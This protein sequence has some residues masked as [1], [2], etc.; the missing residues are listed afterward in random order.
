MALAGA[1]AVAG[2][3]GLLWLASLPLPDIPPS[4][5]SSKLLAVDGELIATL[6]GEENRTVVPLAQI[7]PHLSRAVVA[8]E[9]RTFFD[10][11]GFSIRGIVRAARANWQG[12]GIV[13]G[14]STITQQYVRHAFPDV[15]TDRTLGRKL[16]EAFWAVKLERSS[17]KDEILEHYLNAVYFG[18]GA[19]GAE[20]AAR[21]YFKTSAAQLTAG[22]SAYLAGLI[23][24][25][26][27]YQIDADPARARALRDAVLDRQVALGLVTPGEAAAAKAEDL[28]AQ[29]KPGISIEADSARAGYFV[30]Y[31]RRLL[32][33]EF[34]L[35]D[36]EILRGGLR[37]STTLDLRMQEAAEAAVRGVLNRP[38]D[39][40]AAL[41]AM[42]PSGRIRAMVGGRD[43]DSVERARGFNFA[44][45]VNGTGGG[46]P[47]GSA[48]KTFALAAFLEEGKSIRSTFSGHSTITINSDR[49][50]NGSKPWQVSNYG[51]ECYGYLD[52]TGATTH[53]VNTIYAQ[54][55][56]E[57]VSPQKFIEV[58]TKTGISIPPGDAGCALTLGTSDVTPLEMAGAYTTFA[59]RG[60]RPTPLAVT[61]ITRPSGEVIAERDPSVAQ[62]MDANV[63]D[64]VNH[65]LRQNIESGTGTGA[66]IGRPA[67]GK[68]GTT[69]NFQDAWFAGY[70]PELTT[71]V[72]MGF[73]PD[74]SGRIPLMSRVRGRSVTG[75]SFPATIWKGFMT[76]ALK[77]IPAGDF[78]EPQITGKVISHQPPP[79][80]L[81]P[82]PQLPL[83]R[84]E[85]PPCFP[86]CSML[87][88]DPSQ[89]LRDRLEEQRRRIEDQVRGSGRRLG[90]RGDPDD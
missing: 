59:Q 29:F 37:I 78:P 30:E 18:R 24:A 12:G 21:T 11:E 26:Q 57:V 5:Q 20:A 76:E 64:T 67:A 41:V 62:V 22:Q 89:T 8:V 43:I 66:R 75:G 68:T 60:R 51:N 81:Q 53:S 47:A 84:V 86:F 23:R 73:A 31:V 3:G 48:F 88:Q 65:V 63:A 14:G 54:I 71:V 49:C 82:V 9:D 25:P 33:S 55:M 28:T 83:P 90:Q 42:D 4:A 35:G 74:A 19:Y 27:R 39:P 6:H 80:K 2:I 44:A 85:F 34:K 61:R 38:S 56:N 7:S 16:K 32:K 70:T 52:V 10:H 87:G 17:S 45:D 15:G 50:R 69:E 79:P 36:E 1:L 72:W 40:E 46:R 77:G 58:A 13:Q